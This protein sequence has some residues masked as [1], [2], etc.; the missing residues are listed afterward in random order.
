MP[1]PY[2]RALAVGLLALLIALLGATAVS[3]DPPDPK[4]PLPPIPNAPLAPPTVGKVSG[5]NGVLDYSDLTAHEDAWVAS[6]PAYANQNRGGDQILYVGFD[7]R[8]DAQA[9]RTLLYWKGDVPDGAIVDASFMKLNLYASQGGGSMNIVVR[10]ITGSWTEYGVTWNTMPAY[11]NARDWGS[12]FVGTTTGPYEWDLTDLTRRWANG[13][14]NNQGVILIGDETVR[15]GVAFDRA[16]WS[17]EAPDDSRRP[18][19]Q[20]NYGIARVLNLPANSGTTFTVQWDSGGAASARRWDIEYRRRTFSGSFGGWTRWLSDYSS[21]SAT[22]NAEQGYIYQF[23]VRAIYAD[24]TKAT[25]SLPGN[26]TAIDTTPPTVQWTPPLPAFS[27]PSFTVA[28]LG[29]DSGSGIQNY[30]FEAYDNGNPVTYFT[31]T[32][33]SQNF[34]GGIDG[35]TYTFRV[36][37]RDN[38]GNVS[39]WITTQTVVQTTPPTVTINP[40]PTMSPPTFTVSW[41]GSDN[42]S[43]IKGYQLEIYQDGVGQ[44]AV[45][46]PDTSYVLTN[47]QT[48]STY[49]FRVRAQNNAGIVSEWSP[50]VETLVDGT[51]PTPT[52]SV[53]ARYQVSTNIVV[54]WSATDTVS[55]VS[56]YD[57]QV[58]LNGGGW[59][60]WLHA[61]TFTSGT[62]FGTT[63]NTYAFRVR[64]RDGAGNVSD[65]FTGQNNQTTIAVVETSGRVLGNLGLP[66]AG[67]TVAGTPGA[68]NNN[69]LT[70]GFGNYALYWNAV[71]ARTVN[72]SHPNYLPFAAISVPAASGLQPNVDIY[73]RPQN[74]TVANGNFQSGLTGWTTSGAVTLGTGHSGLQSAA[75]GAGGS[76]T[77]RVSVPN[78]PTPSVVSFLYIVSG[79]TTGSMQVTFGNWSNGQSA[80]VNTVPL[81]GA[82]GWRHA[83]FQLGPQY[84]GAQFDLT[85]SLSASAT[86]TTV[87]VDEISLGA[88]QAVLHYQFMPLIAKNGLLGAPMAASRQEAVDILVMPSEALPTGRPAADSGPVVDL[89]QPGNK[90]TP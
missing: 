29:S 57:L 74:D 84:A 41:S 78:S 43:G 23:R 77:Q 64:A 63:G 75:L 89:S 7:G 71:V 39:D 87:G 48:G 46:T 56:S 72:A 67:A 26:E 79:A 49:S 13:D 24:G 11:D 35:H 53:A 15:P 45:A 5:P 4:Q 47:G 69:A 76:L 86:G 17:R 28:W 38:A 32:A 88:A 62:Y 12:T 14:F 54:T 1:T 21:T 60:D 25:W 82:P 40:L 3:A 18:K 22:F 68:L 85:F 65:W 81:S 80:V 2:R 10:R 31:T 27:Q 66:I 58:S 59:T 34:T 42:I 90:A 9:E 33:T 30:D 6:G 20:I 51:P 44:G 19:L 36:R 16:F 73:L 8:A 50:F 37:A 55:G 61:V 52:L 70:S 83:Y